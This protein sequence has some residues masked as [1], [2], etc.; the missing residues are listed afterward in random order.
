MKSDSDIK[1]DVEAELQWNPDIDA[2]DIA[3]A[4]K[5]GVVEL[6]GFVRSFGQKNEAEG[7]AKRVA[8]VA[9]V[10]NDIEVRLPIFNR[11][12]DPEIARDAVAAVQGELPYS[13]DHIRVGVKDGWITVEGAVDWNYQR[14][15]AEDAG[16]RLRG[17]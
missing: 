16:P 14:K 7:T 3:V 5:N 15:R 8:G 10:A 4:V 11:R 17:V 1:R 13:S 2:T 12:P 9:G 6:T